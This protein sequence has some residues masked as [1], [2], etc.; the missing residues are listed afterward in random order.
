MSGRFLLDTNIII[1]LFASD[2]AVKTRLAET[3]EVFISSVAIG[4]LCF[5][6]RRSTRVQD[7]PPGSMISQSTTL[8]WRVTLKRHADTAR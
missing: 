8:F 4:E 1:A 5:R 7:N 2:A 6:P 3:D